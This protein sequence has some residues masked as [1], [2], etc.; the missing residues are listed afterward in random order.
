MS[1]FLLFL[2][3]LGCSFFSLAQKPSDTTTVAG[4]QFRTDVVLTDNVDPNIPSRAAFYSALLPGAGQLYNKKY[5]KIPIVYGLL[6]GGVWLYNDQNKE[7]NRY[8]DAYRRRLAGFTDDEF[9]NQDTGQQEITNDGLIRSQRTFQRNKELSI[10]L[11]VGVYVLQIV[12]AN[13]DG[14]LRGFTI[15]DDLSF[16][17]MIEY[18]MRSQTTLTGFT[19]GY[20]F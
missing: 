19:I 13:V 9:T 15:D 12:D 20:K 2:G 7:Y 1:K 8:R 18:D 3:A 14:H 17:P 4:G 5:W 11:T 6:G 16:Q 10:L